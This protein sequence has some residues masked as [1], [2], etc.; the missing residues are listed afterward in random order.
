MKAIMLMFDSLNRHMLPPYGCD[1]VQA[2]NFVRLAEKTVKFAKCYAGSLPCMPARRELHTGRYNFLHRSWGP[3]E[4][5]DDSMPQILKE[6]GVYTHLVTDHYHY[7]EDNASTYHTKFSTWESVRG[8]EGDAWK[9]EVGDPETIDTL[10][11]RNP[12]RCRQ[13]WINRKY[14]QEEDQHPLKCTVDLGLDFIRTNK[15]ETN[16]FL[17]LECFSPHEPFFSPQKYKDLYPHEYDGPHFDWPDYQRADENPDINNHIRM[18][19]AAVVSMC[20]NYLG[21]VLDTMDELNLWED[22]LL[23][24]NTD[25]GFLLGEHGWWGK[26]IMPHYNEIANIPLFIWDPRSGKQNME[27]ECLVQTIDIAPTLLDYFQVDI[28]EHMLG[29]PLTNVISKKEPIREAALF[30]IHG[31][32]VNCTDGR[33]VYMR[34]PIDE[35]GGPLYN[36]TLVPLFGFN[37]TPTQILKDLELADPF[38]FTKECKVLKIRGLRFFGG[39][40]YSHLLFDLEKDPKQEEVLVNDEIEKKMTKHLIKLMQENDA[41][42]EQYERLGLVLD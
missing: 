13:D 18:E 42:A 32:H 19:Y 8:Q 15:N 27:N 31:E 20:D 17:Q 36:Y 26:N 38:T 29:Q 25:H 24:V 9:G 41:P 39:R 33:Y 35:S 21:K 14:M 30:G 11:N 1:W 4:P 5:F 7:W 34:A 6:N 23:I 12:E 3:L 37:S 28:P 2:P 22:T 40:K 10:N 16:W